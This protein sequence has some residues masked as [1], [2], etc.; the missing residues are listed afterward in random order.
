MKAPA[1]VKNLKKKKRKKKTLTLSWKKA[2]DANGYE[3][4]QATKAKGKYKKIKT[5]PK[6]RQQSLP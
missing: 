5:I 3:V 6:Q 2:T 1:A 4:Y